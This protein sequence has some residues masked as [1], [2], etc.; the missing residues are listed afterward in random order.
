MMIAVERDDNETTT[1]T[2]RRRRGRREY[3]LGAVP[4]SGGGLHDDDR[5]LLGRVYR[6]ASSV[7]EFG[8]GESTLIASHVG[9]PRYSGVDSDPAWVK[10]AREMSS[11][12][13]NSSHFRFAFA[14]IGP[15][16]AWGKPIDGAD[17]KIPFS[18]QSA[19]LYG[20]VMPFDV[21]YVDGRYRVACLCA[22]MLHAMDRGGDCS[23]EYDVV[24]EVGDI[25]NRSSLL[26][27]FRKKTTSTEDDIVRIWEEHGAGRDVGRR[28]TGMMNVVD[29]GR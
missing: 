3:A 25:V 27:I 15:T 29:S 8:L 28:E 12:E 5:M 2:T 24:L 23:A 7:F 1:T 10:T 4:R 6:D 22:S 19:P 17:P 13:D 20:E 11:R 26:A 9:V 21:Y 14:D 18:Y 16:R